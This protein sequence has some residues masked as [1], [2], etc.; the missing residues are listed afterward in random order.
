MVDQCA[1]MDALATFRASYDLQ[2]KSM[3]RMSDETESSLW[4]E[5]RVNKCQRRP[6]FSQ[7]TK[8]MHISLEIN[9]WPLRLY[10]G[11]L[12]FHW[13]QYF[14]W[15][16]NWSAAAGGGGRKGP[17][18]MLRHFPQRVR[19]AVTS[20]HCWI[21]ISSPSVMLWITISFEFNTKV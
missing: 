17:L 1:L 4:R 18:P 20:F 3:A 2:E 7:Q 14:T 10:F 6:D 15:K 9:K 13:G 5:C 16:L 21:P 11:M 8:K 19:C 12:S